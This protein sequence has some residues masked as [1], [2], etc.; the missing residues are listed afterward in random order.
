MSQDIER[1][2]AELNEAGAAVFPA[3][4]DLAFLRP[5]Q[6]PDGKWTL[7]G[8]GDEPRLIGDDPKS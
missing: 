1:A 4:F 6:A 2:L 7:I 8:D 3:G 5:P